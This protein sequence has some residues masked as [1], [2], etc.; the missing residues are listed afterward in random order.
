M[1]TL[2]LEDLDKKIKEHDQLYNNT[3]FRLGFA[4]SKETHFANYKE[5]LKIQMADLE[6]HGEEL[7]L[8]KQKIESQEKKVI[9][10]SQAG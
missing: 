4:S 1:S 8:Q 10:L 9:N 6:K 5:A 7:L 3:A 2:T